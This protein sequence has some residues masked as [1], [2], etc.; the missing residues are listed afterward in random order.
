MS[1]AI[2]IAIDIVMLCA[3]GLT[4]FFSL[5]L[6]KKFDRLQADRKAFEQ[7]IAALNLAASRSE[8]AIKSLKE[9]AVES[10]DRLQ[11]KV[12]AARALSEELEIVV[13]AGDNLASR[14]G[15]LAEKSRRAQ[16]P[17]DDALP[18]PAPETRTAQPRTRAEKELLEAVKSRQQS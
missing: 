10:G 11:D 5:R 8:L 18:A 7:L 14:L 13:E 3:L 4:I 17:D 15:V 16:A 6:S 1:P 12:N 9:A 2:G